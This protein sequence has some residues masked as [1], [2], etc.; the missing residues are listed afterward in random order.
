MTRHNRG[1]SPRGARAIAALSG[2]VWLVL[3]FGLAD[4]LVVVVNDPGW[5]ESYLLEAGWGVLFGLLVA[6]PLLAY[7]IRP[8]I[9]SGVVVAQL[10]AVAAAVAA[11]AV[12]SG[13]PGQLVPAALVSG[14]ALMLGV[15]AGVRYVPP[16]V[17]GALRLLVIAGAVGGGA[18]A[19]GLV[20][21]HPMV[22]PDITWGLDHLPMQ[23]AIGL[24]V[25]SLGA[26]AAGAVGGRAAGWRVPVWTLVGSI[27][28]L[29]WWSA[30]YP[31]VPGSMDTGLGRAAVIW[32]VAF[33][34]TAEWRARRTAPEAIAA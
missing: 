32:A 28:W 24:V 10:L 27:G 26:V 22:H 30:V 4:L 2:M 19:A 31:D 33:A 15:V 20:E 29:G 34:G 12:W 18:F 14:N 8:S 25:V 1:V 5:R 9:G 11:A 7:A 13:H 6:V 17:D 3:F 16:P 21:N 23:A